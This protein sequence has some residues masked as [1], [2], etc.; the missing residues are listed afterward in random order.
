M[1]PQ[2]KREAELTQEKLA[3]LEN[4]LAEMERR[5]ASGATARITR[6]SLTKLANQLREELIRFRAGAA[7]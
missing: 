4:Q 3:L 7:H 2:T 6:E 5:G 1:T